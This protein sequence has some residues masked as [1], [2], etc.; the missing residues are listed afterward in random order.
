MSD[1]KRRIGEALQKRRKFLKLTTRQVGEHM[2]VKHNTISRWETGFT[3][4]SPKKI[5]KL[6]TF[7]KTSFATILQTA[8]RLSEEETE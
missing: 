5:D 7:Y 8:K 2:G 1:I 3:T 4:V 6:C